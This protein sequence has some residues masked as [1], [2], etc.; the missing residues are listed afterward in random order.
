MWAVGT[1]D[2]VVSGSFVVDGSSSYTKPK[3]F[4][5]SVSGAATGVYTVT[6]VEAVSDFKAV[7][8]GVRPE[9][10]ASV[11]K[12]AVVTSATPSTGVIVISCAAQ[13]TGDFAASA[14]ASGD[15]VNFVAVCRKNASDPQ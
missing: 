6:L 2:F 15:I 13:S 1:R 10:S 4:G 7:L 5:W 11:K 8:A 9:G 12:T 3:G 14:L